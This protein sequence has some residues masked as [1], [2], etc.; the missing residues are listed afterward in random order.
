MK[1]ESIIRQWNDTME[2]LFLEHETINTSLSVL[3]D[4]PNYWEIKNG[5]I[6][7]DWMLDE[8]YYWESQYEKGGS[9]EFDDDNELK[10]LEKLI[11]ILGKEEDSGDRVV[12][13]IAVKNT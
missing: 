11:S 7:L 9:R 4:D 13:K 8:A 3:G 5:E 6:T 2:Y 12:A 10:E 1:N